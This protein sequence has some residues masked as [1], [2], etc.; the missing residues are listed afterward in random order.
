MLLSY[1]PE[2]NEAR[3]AGSIEARMGHYGNHWYCD[4]PLTL[5]GR[6]VKFL[7]TMTA[8]TLVPGSRKVGW[9]K[10]KV[11]DAA[12]DKLCAQYDVVTENNL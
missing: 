1:C 3:P 9:N 4:T 6:G 12:F 8:A 11:T 7:E 5:S 2:M 10:Y